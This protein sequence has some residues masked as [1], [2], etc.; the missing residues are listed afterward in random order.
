MLP[1]SVCSRLGRNA[2]R[3]PAG[4]SLIELMI[5]LSIAAFLIG[6]GTPWWGSWIAT[7]RLNNHA[8][9][10]AETL[11]LARSEA[12]KRGTRVNVCKTRDGKECADEGGWDQ[13]WILFV[14][15]NDNGRVDDGEPVLHTEPSVEHR[16]TVV[17]NRPVE[18]YV[19]YT[20]L[21]H[22]RLLNGALQ[23]GTFLL[24]K[25]GQ[26]SIKVVLANSGRAR[27]EKTPDRCP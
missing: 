17:G 9:H 18:D 5:A 4:F 27:I 15:E 10:V 19:S 25:P 2:R 16:I 21:G 3:S 7:Q 23:M 20:A 1:P 11:N 13:G 8:H 12:I 22:A 26:T 14:D 24:C 6:I